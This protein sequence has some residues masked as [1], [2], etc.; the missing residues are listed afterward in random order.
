M[1]T[2]THCVDIMSFKI[3]S[4]YYM[5]LGYL[6]VWL[7]PPTDSS[8]IQDCYWPVEG[9]HEYEGGITVNLKDTQEFEETKLT[10]RTFH[11]SMAQV[12]V[13]K[14]LTVDCQVIITIS[15]SNIDDPLL[16]GND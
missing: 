13:V 4:Y 14:S 8:H 15:A 2:Q 10:K 16:L 6:W 7:A 11:V 3:F 1:D 5:V 9:M 12:M